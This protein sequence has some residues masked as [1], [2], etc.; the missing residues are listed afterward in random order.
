M[1]LPC[2]GRGKD[3]RGGVVALDFLH[4]QL[5]DDDREPAAV[6]TLWACVAGLG[7]LRSGKK[8]RLA[9]EN[10]RPGRDLNPCYR[11]ESGY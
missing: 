11:R 5:A 1:A 7:N 8:L 10:W 4:R 9:E 3:V 2:F 6:L